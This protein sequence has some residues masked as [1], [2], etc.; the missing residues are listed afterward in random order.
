MKKSLFAMAA[1]TAFAGA[2]Q[3]QSSVTVYGILDVGFTGT[4]SRVPSIN[5]AAAYKT[6]ATSFNGGGNESTSRLGFK[7]NEDLGG[8]VNAF[9]TAEMQLSAANSN[10]YINMTNRQTFVGLGKKGLGQ[11]AIG[12]QYTPIHLAVG[13][14]DPGQANNI[15]GNVIY[16]VN[17][18]TANAS[19]TYAYTVR[20]NN[21]LTFATDSFAGFKLNG[22]YGITNSDRTQIGTDNQYSSAAALTSTAGGNTN[23]TAW[24][25]GADY[26]WNK[27]FASF[28]YQNIKNETNNSQVNITAQTSTVNTT[29]NEVGV[30]VSSTQYYGAAVYDFGILKAYAQYI[31]NKTT[32]TLSSAVY[33]KRTAQQLGVRSFVTPKIETWASVGNGRISA[34]G[35]DEP[36]AN[37]TAYQLGANYYLSK[38]T[39]LYGI[40]GS[41]QTSTVNNSSTASSYD[42]KG[43]AGNS[44][45]AVGVRHTF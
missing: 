21:A 35:T 3:A 29:A 45:Y 37:F 42:V 15:M 4:T 28:A 2:A 44:G 38:R 19:S 27:L 7:G 10:N 43:A 32:S 36:T 20:Q 25:L 23:N 6:N 5:D 11:A 9:F 17:T 16:S 22:L 14:T 41:T 30:N 39:N 40:F 8:G 18:T 26:T 33:A 1:V 13:A 24:G 34:F 12:T 31:N